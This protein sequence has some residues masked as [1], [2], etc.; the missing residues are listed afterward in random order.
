[1]NCMFDRDLLQEYAIGEIVET[2]RSTVEAHLAGCA[3][4]RL[5]VADL[6]RLARDLASI[7]E[8]AFPADLEEVLVRAA[9][10]AGRAQ[11]P[12]RSSSLRPNSLRR[13]WTLVLAGSVGLAL[14]G[15]MVV[16]LWPPRWAG[17]GVGLGGG[18]G[19]GLADSLWGWAETLRT[20]W[21]TATDFLERFEPVR[22]AARAGLGG[23]TAS[24]VGAMG[25][26]VVA[27]VLVLWRIAGPRKR[28]VNHAKPQ[29]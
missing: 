17:L 21:N 24:L 19:L 14:A 22:K 18:Q 27:T 11:Q 20:F 12:V 6:R 15:F 25:L 28:K 2:D 10:Q 29:Y 16:S 7:P 9:I 23:L 8:P 3:G 26:G 4:C 1:M 5:E 13:S